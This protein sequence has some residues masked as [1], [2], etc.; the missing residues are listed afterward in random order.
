MNKIA[1]LPP[2]KT[3]GNPNRA[4]TPEVIGL[5][6]RP[7][8]DTRI[9]NIPG[10]NAFRLSASIVK[11]DQPSVFVN[12]KTGKC[13]HPT[14]E[15]LAIMAFLHIAGIIKTEPGNKIL[16]THF[17]PDSVDQYGRAAAKI[18]VLYKKCVENPKT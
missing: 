18:I 12:M 11:S 10:T 9:Y 6:D 5:N 13:S 7:S 16:G 8:C 2:P 17:N 4:I 15:K 3:R 14:F 1:L